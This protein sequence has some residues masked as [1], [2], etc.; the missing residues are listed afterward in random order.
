MV[1]H[2]VREETSAWRES[3]SPDLGSLSS[4]TDNTGGFLF[5]KQSR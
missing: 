4:R 5:F 1:E 3:L 2:C